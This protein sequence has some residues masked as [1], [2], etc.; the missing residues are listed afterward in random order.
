MNVDLRRGSAVILPENY[1]LLM[2]HKVY[3][4]DPEVTKLSFEN[5]DM[6]EDP[7][8][9]KK[10]VAALH[11]N[12]HLTELNL[13]NSNLKATEGIPLGLALKENETLAVLNIESSFLDVPG[14]LSIADGLKVNRSLS[15]LKMNGL[16]SLP[17]GCGASVEEAFAEAMKTNT[18][19]ERLGLTLQL[20]NHRDVIDRRLMQNG[21]KRRR[22]RQTMKKLELEQGKENGP[23]TVQPSGYPAK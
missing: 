10:L 15:T 11:R 2:V 23:P 4:N 17:K 13:A 3:M 7:R 21:D 22:T 6:K 18:T 5:M 9:A 8:I 1:M 14:L 20:P 16:K 12:T 19:L